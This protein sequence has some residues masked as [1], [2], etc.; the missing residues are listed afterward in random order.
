MDVGLVCE[1]AHALPEGV[2]VRVLEDVDHHDD[3]I[4]SVK[5]TSRDGKEWNEA[6][7][8]QEVLDGLPRQVEVAVGKVG[9]PTDMISAV[10]MSA[11]LCGVRQ[12]RTRSG[13]V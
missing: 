12:S 6:S 13:N 10:N 8:S 5:K 2:H 11:N 4:E 3:L 7:D 9:N 1:P